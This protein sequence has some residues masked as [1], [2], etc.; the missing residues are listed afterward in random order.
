MNILVISPVEGEVLAPAKIE[1][2][3][4]V[5]VGGMAAMGRGWVGNTHKEGEGDGL[6]RCLLR[7]RE[8]E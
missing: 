8:R 1:P 3:V 5:I 6:G 2:P 4:N 7:N